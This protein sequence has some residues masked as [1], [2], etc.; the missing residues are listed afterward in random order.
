MKKKTCFLTII[1]LCLTLTSCGSRREP[2]T[3][4]EFLMDTVVTI[5]LCDCSKEAVLDRCFEICRE[6]E[7]ML[8]RTIESSDIGRLNAAAEA[9]M[10]EPLA[11]SEETLELIRLGL[12]YGELSEGRF[13]ISIAPLSTLWEANST[14][15]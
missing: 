7:A 10:T 11:V 8:S 3:R 1:I 12:E 2:L 14:L 6:Y 13:D 15:S 5:T 4:T 9:G